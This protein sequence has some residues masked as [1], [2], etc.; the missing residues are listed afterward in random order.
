MEL[1]TSTRR[2]ARIGLT[3]LIDV[4]FILLLF[5]MLASSLADWRGLAVSSG[6]SVGTGS[7]GSGAILVRIGVDGQL[8]INGVAV[9]EA[10]LPAA[11][12]R[13]LAQDPEQ[14]VL[15]QPVPSLSVQRVVSVYDLLVSLGVRR[16]TLDGG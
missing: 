7:A 8:D 3:P 2:Q 1:E 6:A 5:F 14:A 4:V 13:Y 15:L 9:A 11:L 12:G 16:L 10:E